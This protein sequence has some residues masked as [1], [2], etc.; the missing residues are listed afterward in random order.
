MNT[1]VIT[2]ADRGLG[3]ALC[4]CFLQRGWRVFAG[5]YM[6]DWPQLAKLREASGDRLMIV[7]LDTSDDASVREAMRSV[8]SSTG[9]VDLL[10]HNAGIT[11][12]TDR[13]TEIYDPQIDYLTALDGLISPRSLTSAYNVNAVGA[14]RVTR[15]LLALMEGGMKR[16]CFVSSEAG[17]IHASGRI[18]Y[19]GYT[20]SKAALNAAVR[21]LHRELSP[22]G[23]TFRMYHPGWL[24]S[25]M[26]GVINTRATVEPEDSA[27]TA[28]E[29]FLRKK[30]CET[31]LE[32]EDNMGMIWPN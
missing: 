11:G 5:Q 18:D 27:V 1:A 8:S 6:P 3:Y 4:E 9:H 2:G 7:P 15:E 23:F 25:Y 17:S 14:L 32:M 21:G 26:N 12:I 13:Q 28:V 29:L 31:V 19:Y 16:L 20:M 10:A 22:W 30:P 24:R